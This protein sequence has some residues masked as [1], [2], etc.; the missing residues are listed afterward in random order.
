M[1]NKSIGQNNINRRP[2]QYSSNLN[3]RPP[4]QSSNLNAP[5]S[6]MANRNRQNSNRPLKHP[7]WRN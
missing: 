4:Q 1:A 7:L 3:R 2:N 6:N 5:R